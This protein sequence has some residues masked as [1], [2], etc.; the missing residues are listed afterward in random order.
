MTKREQLEERLADFPLVE[1]GYLKADQVEFFDRVRTV[2]REF[3]PQY[4]KSWACPPAVGTVEECQTRCREFTDFFVFSTM[5][6]VEDLQ[7]ME[8]TLATRAG[9]EGITRG[10]REVFREIYGPC[11]VLST[12]SCGICE[13]CAY[14]TE[15][16]RHPE[17]MLPC[18]ESHGIVVTDLAEKAQMTFFQDYNTVVW[19]SAVF[20]NSG[21]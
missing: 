20:Y 12:E 16:C 7:N 14:P 3:C 11:L 9:H 2:C 15:P 6:E 1:Y 13:T 21:E 4:G 8:E 18:V 19:F 5:A 10:I 17:Y